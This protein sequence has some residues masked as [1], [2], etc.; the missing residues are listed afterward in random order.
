M[1]QKWLEDNVFGV[2]VLAFSGTKDQIKKRCVE[3][4]S[5]YKPGES[6]LGVC[7]RLSNSRGF[8]VWLSDP[9]DFYSLLHETVHLVR[10]VFEDRGVNTDLRNED[11]TFA[12]YQMFWFRELWRFFGKV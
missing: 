5:D 11:E 7:R 3:L 12:Y 6:T 9:Q 2:D 10:M 8:L 1:K 4:E